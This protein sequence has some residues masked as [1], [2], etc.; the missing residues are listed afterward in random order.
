MKAIGFLIIGIGI[1]LALYVGGYVFLLGG[2]IG[3]IEQ[4]KA[5]NIETMVLAW[6]IVKILM[7]GIVGYLIGLIFFVVGGVLSDS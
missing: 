7:A 1:L 5:E 6:S 3:V 2:I 4:I